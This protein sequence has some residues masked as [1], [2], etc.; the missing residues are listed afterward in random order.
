MVEWNGSNFDPADVNGGIISGVNGDGGSPTPKKKKKDKTPKPEPEPEPLPPPPVVGV[1]PIGQISPLQPPVPEGQISIQDWAGQVALDPK[2]AFTPEMLLGQNVPRY[3]QDQINSGLIGQQGPMQG[4]SAGLGQAQL[5]TAEEIQAMDP[6]TYQAYMSQQQILNGVGDIQAAT[7]Q[8]S[9]GAQ[10]SVREIDVEAIAQGQNALGRALKDFAYL[11]PNDVDAKATIVG[12]MDLLQ[13]QFVDGAGNPT[14]PSWATGIARN[15]SKIAAFKGVTGTAAT[16]ALSNAILESTIQIAQKDAQFF[17]T[18]TLQNLN[19]EQQSTI[20][21]AAVLANM[22]T[23]NLDARTTI[24]V[25]NSRA[26]LQMDMANLSNEQQAAIINGQARIQS[27][28]ED[29]KAEN[30]ARAFN[31]NSENEINQF[32]SQLGAQIKQF[33]ATQSN[34]VSQYNTD[35]FN[36]NAQFNASMENSRDLFYRNMQYQIDTANATWRQTVATDETR[37][38]FEANALDVKNMVGMSQ[39]QLNRLWDRSDSLLDYIWKATENQLDR[40]SA[41]A[42]AKL[43]AKSNEGIA[44]RNADAQKSSAWGDV[45][46][47]IAGTI[48]GSWFS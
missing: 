22:E 3:T 5:Y 20:Q 42:I 35:Q 29:A 19:N 14:I 12:Q 9:Q 15:V 16:A 36:Q 28:M 47:K 11:D 4:I 38:L 41:L 17:Q 26:F 8:V 45:F 7:G 18:L 48:I 21:R 24:A 32:Y 46:G 2:L 1:D 23:R 43:Q 30:V 25:E 33:N 13:Q 6:A 31:A 27:I 40:D 37:M 39:E 34:L 44:R 10:A